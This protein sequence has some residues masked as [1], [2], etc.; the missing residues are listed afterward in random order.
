MTHGRTL[1]WSG[2]TWN[3]KDSSSSKWGPGPNY[4]SSSN[5]NVWVDNEGRLHLKITKR[6]GKW[7]CA[8][9]YNIQTLGYGTYRFF[10][11]GRPDKLDPNI[12][13][14][15]FTYDSIS[16]DAATN[17]NREI[18]IEFAKWGNSN[19][20]NSQY[21]VQPYT[22]SSNIERFQTSLNGY[23]STHTFKWT[24][25]EIKFMS[26]HGHY[27]TLPSP[28]EWYLIKEWSYNGEDIPNTNNEK[29]RLNLWLMGG[30][31]PLNQH[32]AEIIITKFEFIPME[33]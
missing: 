24:S 15:L 23:R 31:A 19:A 33:N 13:L 11:D 28:L 25:S 7:Y 20:L 22:K 14:G 10:I 17:N 18:D 26:L 1:N 4:F 5:E 32:E 3:V 30:G 16:A 21:V 12:T 29:V 6:K 9:V 2:Y 27:S 8:E